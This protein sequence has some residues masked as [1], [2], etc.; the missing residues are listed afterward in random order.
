MTWTKQIVSTSP[1]VSVRFDMTQGSQSTN[2]NYTNVNWS[3]QSITS[4]GTRTGTWDYNAYVNGTRVANGSNSST[5]SGTQT[6]ASGSIRVNH[7]AN[8]KKTVSGSG[9]LDA[10][11]G[12]GTVSGS[13]TLSR[14]ARAPYGLTQSHNSVT[15]TSAKIVLDISNRGHGTSASHEAQYRKGTSGSY[16]GTPDQ[17]ITDTQPNT[18]TLSGLTPNTLYQY[19]QRVWNNNGDE[20]ISSPSSFVTLSEVYQAGT[21]EIQ[22]TSYTV[23]NARAYQGHHTTT[24]K[25]QYRKKGTTTWL[26]SPTA[27]GDNFSITITGLMPGTTYERRFVCT[28]SAGTTT[29]GIYEF[30]TPTGGTIIYPDGTTKTARFYVVYPNGTVKD[31]Q[32]TPFKGRYGD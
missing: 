20:A 30:T 24:S 32:V 26:D 3:I 8:G 17:S 9:W 13:L 27:T 19:R 10:Y 7:D 16:S 12:S 29:N 14:I 23:T 28:T 15:T 2:G 25:I 11:F 5:H 6:L 31:A 21:I 4:G 18:F 1:T 22:P